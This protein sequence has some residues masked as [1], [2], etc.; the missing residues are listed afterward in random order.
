MEIIVKATYSKWATY[1]L[2]YPCFS[3]LNPLRYSSKTALDATTCAP[4]KPPS[5]GISF[6]FSTS[7]VS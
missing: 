7:L 4:S 1:Y 2:L 3:S 5:H 6:V